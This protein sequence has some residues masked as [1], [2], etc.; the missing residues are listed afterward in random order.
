M[1]FADLPRYWGWLALTGASLMGCAAP[2]PSVPADAPS[3]TATASSTE[4]VGVTAGAR[5]PAHPRSAAGTGGKVVEPPVRVPAPDVAP[6]VQRAFDDARRALRAGRMD[7]AQHGLDALAQAHPEL[8][9]VH[10]NLGVIHRQAGRLP[11]AVAALE[12][13]VKAS[14]DQPQYWNQLGIARRMLGQFGPA[15]EAYGKA[16]ALDP[17]YAAPVLNLGILNDLYLGDG[18]RALELY[19]RYLAL[20]PG[21]DATVDKWVIDLKNRKADGVALGRKEQP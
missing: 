12:R 4:I 7:E 3:A 6:E 10:A 21:G 11:L 13:A 5:A 19:G 16:I 2:T 15:R 9:G 17:G 8:G 18:R 1:Q 14:P 20:S